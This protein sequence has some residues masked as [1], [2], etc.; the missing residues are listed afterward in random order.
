[1]GLTTQPHPG[2]KASRDWESR[3]NPLGLGGGGSHGE[4]EMPVQGASTPG[5]TAES[6]AAPGGVGGGLAEPP[7]G[8]ATAQP[9]FDKDVIRTVNGHTT[10]LNSEKQLKHIP[11]SPYYQEGKSIL[12]VSLQEAQELVNEF[13]GTGRFLNVDHTKERVDFGRPVGFHVDPRTHKR[14]MTTCGLI[15][16]S[17]IGTHIVP[18]L[19]DSE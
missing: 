11:D 17:Q 13:A 1:M 5:R 7:Q 15:H 6:S 12:T 16:Y 18:A 3:T 4:A 2:S 14:L 9:R 8:G 10:R 19:P